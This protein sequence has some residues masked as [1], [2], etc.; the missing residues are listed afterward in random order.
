[1]SASRL[2][3]AV[4]RTGMGFSCCLLALAGSSNLQTGIRLMLCFELH[5]NQTFD[6]CCFSF[7]LCLCL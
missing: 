4:Q 2:W 7:Q 1:M 5:P 6:F 3:L